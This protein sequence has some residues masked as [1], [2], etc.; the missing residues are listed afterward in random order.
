MLLSLPKLFIFQKYYPHILGNTLEILVATETK[1]K[2][3]VL[4]R[5]LCSTRNEYRPLN[6][7][8]KYL[9]RLHCPPPMKVAGANAKILNK[10][11]VLLLLLAE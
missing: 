6:F 10:G 7:T 5:Q 3:F 2:S 11:D 1:D 8:R 9:G 4:Q